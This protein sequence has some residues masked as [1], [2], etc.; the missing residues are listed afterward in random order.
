MTLRY[1]LPLTLALATPA[2]AD[3]TDMSDAERAAFRQE[4]RAYLLENP[5]VL[6][7]AIA[8]LEGQQQQA[9]VQ[10]DDGLVQSYKDML[11]DDGHSW[12]GGNLEG[13]IT[14]VEFMDYRC[15]YCRRAFED[16]ETIVANDGNIR[17]I[18]K[19]FPILGEQSLLSSKL[20]IAVK[21][22]YGD[23]TYKTLHDVLIA[24]NTD[25]TPDTVGRLAAAY[26][27][28]ATALLAEM[29]SPETA[30]II[31]ANRALGNLMQISGTPTFIIGDRMVRGYVAA[32]QMLRII[33]DERAS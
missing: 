11:L 20:A 22:L 1:A 5:S 30:A 17:F 21:A 4:V 27:L 10:M 15:G 13:D 8:V 25:L 7:E 29:D 12:V 3:I 19:E 16:V 2:V 18:V 26:D 6:M 24:L 14:I 33:A 31:D 28:D 9:Q 23:E 32:E